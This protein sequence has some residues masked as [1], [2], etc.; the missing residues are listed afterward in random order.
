MATNIKV[1]QQFGRLTVL[2][3]LPRNDGHTSWWKCRCS[4][5]KEKDVRGTC[6]TQGFTKSCGC[7]R[8]EGLQKH[9][10]QMMYK[11]GGYGTPL[12]KVWRGMIQRCR[13]KTNPSYH[14]YGERGIRVCDEWE[15]DFAS[16]REWAMANGYEEGLSIDRIDVNGNYEP[17]NCRWLTMREQQSNK[18]NNVYVTYN[19]ETHTASEW[20]R[21]VGTY[22]ARICQRI[23]AGW[24]DPYEIIYGRRKRYGN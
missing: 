21:R 12:Y 1:G 9:G 13:N 23:K 3:R 14:L 19:G 17:S 16:F 8:R 24:S 15:N 18:R 10:Y 11:H 5:G 2:E 6:L 20:A 7:L 4:C 22:P